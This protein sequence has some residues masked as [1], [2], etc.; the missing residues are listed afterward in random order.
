MRHS[1]TRSGVDSPR[2]LLASLAVLLLLAGCAGRPE[3]PVAAGEMV[4]EVEIAARAGAWRGWPADLA[5]FAT[6]IHVRIVNRGGSVLRVSHDDFALVAGGR[7]LPVVL[8]H[9]VRGVV[10]RPPPAALPSAGFAP[11]TADSP[12]GRDWVLRG[13]DLAA[14]ADP[15]R[16]GEQFALPSPAML[17]QALPEG[18]VRPGERASGFVY[19]EPLGARTGPAELSVRL[20]D[21]GTGRIVDRAV[22][23]VS[24]P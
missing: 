20:I 15:A 17:A 16:V 5:R 9:E 7:R 22:I 3:P 6:P 14:E 21:A 12:A 19:F 23:P 8:P 10:S 11:G 24:P 4:S 2:L 13:P 1:S 18:V